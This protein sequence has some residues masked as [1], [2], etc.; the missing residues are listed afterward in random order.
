[1]R[2]SDWSSDVCSSDLLGGQG[3]DPRRAAPG[4]RRRPALRQRGGRG[5]GGSQAA[6]QPPGDA[7][8]RSQGQAGA[9]GLRGS[10]G[11]L[12]RLEERRGGKECVSTCRPRW[13]RYQEKKKKNNITVNNN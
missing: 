6:G 11:C 10:G 5:R 13:S 7:A 8:D 4:C 1:M 2:I 3:A 12:R 9:L